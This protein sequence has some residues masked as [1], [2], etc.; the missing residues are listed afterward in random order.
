MAALRPVAIG[1]LLRRIWVHD[2]SRAHEMVQEMRYE[3]RRWGIPRT[4]LTLVEI[5]AGQ[6]TADAR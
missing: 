1:L 3:V 2:S 6:H 4:R 5:M